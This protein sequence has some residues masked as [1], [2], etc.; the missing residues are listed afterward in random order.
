MKNAVACILVHSSQT[1]SFASCYLHFYIYFYLSTLQQTI[2]NNLSFAVV[3]HS[4]PHLLND[5][6]IYNNNK[7][8][9]MVM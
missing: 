5:N 4:S 3:L 8:I 7:I 1:I 2:I 6:N 9:I